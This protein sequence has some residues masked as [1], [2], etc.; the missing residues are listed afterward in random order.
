MTQ[1]PQPRYD[2][3]GMLAQM[4][5]IV[6]QFDADSRGWN[7]LNIYE[8]LM[9]RTLRALWD[10]V[11]HSDVN[12]DIWTTTRYQVR[13]CT[14]LISDVC[15]LP[16]WDEV[17]QPDSLDLYHPTIES[18]RWLLQVTHEEW[19]PVT[20]HIGNACTCRAGGVM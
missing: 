12:Q 9:L 19:C 16:G 8:G 11:R 2:A 1:D 18:L 7:D 4:R 5:S 3:Y 14:A 20:D 6:A 13:A 10:V 17:R 15:R